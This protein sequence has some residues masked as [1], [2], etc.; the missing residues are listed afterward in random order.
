MAVS[1]PQPVSQLV[2]IG[3]SAGGVETLSA[4]VE[5]LPA[6]FPAPIIV[7]QHLD[8][9]RASHLKSILARRSTLP[10]RTVVDKEALEP[11]V[12]YVVPSNRQVSFT[13]HHVIIEEDGPDRPKPSIDLLFRSAAAVFGEGLIAM[14]LSGLG[15]DGAAGAR[16]VKEAG[17]TVVIQNPRTAPYPSMPRSLA[18]T[19]VDV[20]TDVD[21]MGTLLYDLLTGS[22]SPVGPSEDRQLRVFLAELRERSGIDFAQY[23]EP[24]IQRRLQRRLMATG[25]RS[26]EEYRLY[27][28]TH[29]EEY[30]CLVNAFL[31]KVTEFFR[32]ADLFDHL[33]AV[34]IPTL[35][36]E[37]RERDKTLRLWSAGCATG[38][39]AYSLALL[40]AEALGEEIAGWTVRI[41]ATDLDGAAVDFARRGVYPAS[42]LEAVPATLLA[43][44]FT[45]A[46]EGS[47]SVD[48]TVRGLL[49]FGEHDLG[50]RPPFP[51]VDLCLCRNVLIYFTPELQRRA[52]DLF[53]F[54]LRDGGY[55]ALGKAETTGSAEDYFMPVQTVPRLYRRRGEVHTVPQRAEAA[56]QSSSRHGRSDGRP[57]VQAARE[58]ARMR[59]DAQ[60]AQGAQFA[61]EQLLLHLPLGVAV[62]D[63][64]YDI[65]RINGAARRLL[66]I[67]EAALGE[68]LT[69]LV[70]GLT[71]QNQHDLREALE[72]AVHS[73]ASTL[74]SIVST[75]AEPGATR[76]LRIV[77]APYNGRRGVATPI[78]AVGG[79][80]GAGDARVLL[81][82]EDVTEQEEARAAVVRRDATI[83]GLQKTV[84]MLRD[85]N[86]ELSVENVLARRSS[87]ESILSNEEVQAAAEEVE[88]LNEELQASNEELETLNDKLRRRQ[89][90]GEKLAAA[91]GAQR[92]RLAA[93]LG[94]LG[95]AVLVLD[96]EGRVVFANARASAL[97]GERGEMFRASDADGRLL[98][99][100]ATPQERAR[101]SESFEMTFTHARTE[102]DASRRWYE[103]TGRPV[104]DAAEGE[105]GTGEEG[106][107]SVLVIRDITDRTLRRLQD[108]FLNVASHELRTPLTPI[109]G[110]LQMLERGLNAGAR[111]PQKLAG[112]AR[113]ARA[114]MGR[115]QRL[116]DDLLDVSRLESGK[117]RLRRVRTN[118]AD[119]AHQAVGSAH[120]LPDGEHV[121]LDEEAARADPL[122]VDGDAVRIEQVVLNLLTNALTHAPA[123]EI[124]VELRG[125]E[126]AALT[127]R[128]DGPGIPLEA[129]PHLF[130]R[131]YQAEQDARGGT[132]GPGLG[133]GLYIAREIVEAHG[134]TL[135]LASTP[136]EGAAFT[137]TLPLVVEEP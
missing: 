38:E 14:V 29:S 2:A 12:V 127:V 78:D 6:N 75:E 103:A 88:T 100:E 52:L 20:V 119:V 55:L 10:V 13:D 40:V 45:A 110:Y 58:L 98:P 87:E 62:L 116:I 21:A 44:Y 18:P 117:L 25:T 11:G 115:M 49:V 128:D 70:R 132:G 61:A 47:Y 34:V 59:E 66:G 109:S 50:Q 39:E 135:T 7:A 1:T 126:S 101:R 130:T 9:T 54:A 64:R 22:Y 57:S 41:F 120:M 81:T 80:Q 113:T 60:R 102:L 118:L 51:R 68:D 91:V 92:R 99:L 71:V 108:A 77:C 83:E 31:I 4:L 33:R 46:E 8:P 37:G 48:K 30:D 19:T 137:V 65:Q 134:G 28:E 121:R 16:R 90:E 94:S 106:G 73:V 97:F 104:R 36:A 26:L 96:G 131:F 84:R 133:L 5:T 107:D 122:W 111:E 42:A 72:G 114:Q 35:I 125:G 86:E 27:L 3:A 15:S 124:T 53:A 105:T 32:D 112:Y 17:G 76:L 82:I 69:H 95:E 136:G 123:A 74:A 43:R 93:I 56:Q 24:T 63:R 85:A 79:G 23:K 89:R 129:Q 67:H